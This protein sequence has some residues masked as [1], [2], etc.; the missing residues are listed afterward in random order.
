MLR[1]YAKIGLDRPTRDQWLPASDIHQVA[2][3]TV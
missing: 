3:Q 2:Q 1:R